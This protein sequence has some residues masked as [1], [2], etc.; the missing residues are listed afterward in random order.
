MDNNFFSWH[1]VGQ[2]QFILGKCPKQPRLQKRKSST[3][4]AKNCCT[5]ISIKSRRV[6]FFPGFINTSKIGHLSSLQQN[7]YIFCAKIFL[8]L[9]I[10][11]S[12]TL[13]K[14]KE[15][16]KIWHCAVALWLQ[17]C[18]IKGAPTSNLRKI[19]F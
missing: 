4:Y 1:H 6:Y 13:G 5:Y 16:S 12:D 14:S 8:H 18:K 3:L 10:G 15:L 9:E 19:G 11:L 7:N 2:T 17:T